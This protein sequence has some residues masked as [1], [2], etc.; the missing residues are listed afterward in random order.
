V[1]LRDELAQAAAA[2]LRFAGSGEEVAGVLA[3]EPH[4]GRRLYLCA[5]RDGDEQVS[6]LSLDVD[7]EPVAERAVVRE[8]ASI[9]ALCELAEESAGGGDLEQLRARLVTLRLTENPIGIDE[10]EAAALALERTI[11]SPPRIASPEYLDAVGTATM[12]LELALGGPGA[13]PFAAAMKAGVD[14]VDLFVC[15]VE[16]GYKLELGG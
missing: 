1:A 14:V 15:D 2:A 5:F 4:P 3:A 9:V 8:A 6:W 10:A 7:R 13:S 16:L 11:G 12:A